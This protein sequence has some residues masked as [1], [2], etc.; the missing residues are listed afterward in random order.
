MSEDAVSA[1]G[2][3]PDALRGVL[4]AAAAIWERLCSSND[5]EASDARDE[6]DELIAPQLRPCAGINEK[7][8]NPRE[9]SMTGTT[10]VIAPSATTAWIRACVTGW[11]SA[12][13]SAS[14]STR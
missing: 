9:E 7:K 11:A 12:F 10:V 2:S 6:F 13:T 3:R 8:E 14:V 4:T 5:V 1:P